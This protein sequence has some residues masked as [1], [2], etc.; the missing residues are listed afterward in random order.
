MFAGCVESFPSAS[1]S[2]PFSAVWPW[3]TA[4][5]AAMAA[6]IEIAAA[7]GTEGETVTGAGT[8]GSAAPSAGRIAASIAG[9]SVRTA[10]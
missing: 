4:T 1:C 9:R 6:A 10:G 2:S 5:V 7:A 3:Q 8:A